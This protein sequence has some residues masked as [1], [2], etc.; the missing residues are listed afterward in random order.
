MIKKIILL[1]ILTTS[2]KSQNATLNNNNGDKVIWSIIFGDR[3]KESYAD[4][5]LNE[6]E[7]IKN[8]YLNSDESDG[9]TNV[10]VKILQE[11]GN[12]YISTSQDKTFKAID[13][14]IDEIA[15]NVIYKGIE[16]KF[17]FKKEN[18]KFLIISDDG[19]GKIIIWQSKKQPIF[20]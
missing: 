5:L 7:I 11:K 18:G 9:V 14:K 4:L 15:L 19:E 1:L 17:K 2:C 16:E 6:Q 13:L 12:Y 3:F 20:D 8:V 10:W